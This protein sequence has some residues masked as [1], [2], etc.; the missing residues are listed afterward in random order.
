LFLGH[1]ANWQFFKSLLEALSI[2]LIYGIRCSSLLF[3]SYSQP[4]LLHRTA[5]HHQGHQ[6]QVN[7]SQMDDIS[8]QISDLA[9]VEEMQQDWELQAEAK[10]E[11]E[12]LLRT[13]P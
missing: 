1:F 11:L 8:A 4:C 13:S 12:R 5:V 9:D 2:L 6:L 10:D 3:G 7:Q